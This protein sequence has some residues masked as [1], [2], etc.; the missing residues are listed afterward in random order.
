MSIDLAHSRA[1]FA[2]VFL[3]GFSS[4]L[5]FVPRA[6]AQQAG[7]ELPTV[8]VVATTPLGAGTSALNVPNETQ[9]LDSQQIETLSQSTITE[10]MARRTPGV[11]TTDSIGSPLAQSL[12]FR[13]ET[14]SPVPGTPQGL[15]VYMNGVRINESYGDVVNWDLIPTVA[16]DTAQ[17][18]TG[19]PVFGLNALAGAVVMNMKNGFTLQ[20]TEFD[21]QGGSDYTVQGS[22]QYGVNKGNWAYYVATEGVRT[23]GYRYFGQSDVERAYGDVGYRAEGNEVHLSMTGGADGL[24]VAGSTPLILSQQNPASVFTTPQTTNT[25]AEMI[26][27]SDESH[28]NDKLKFNGDIYFRNYGQAHVDGN[29]SNFQS[30]GGATLCNNGNPTAI[31]DTLP[32]GSLYGEIDRNWTHTES[33]GATAQLTYDDKIFGHHNTLTAGVSVDHGWTH[34]VGNSEIGSLATNFVV[35]GLGTYINEPASD[36]SPVNLNAQNT[37]LGIY[38]LDDFD[39]TDRLTLHAGARFNDA[40]INLNDL[41]GAS[42]NLNANNNFNRINPVVGATFKI[43]PDI[44]AYASYSEANRAPTP[45]ELGCSSPSQPCMIDN[46]LVSDPPLKQVVARTVEAGF[47]G[48]NPISGPIPGRLDWSANFYRTENQN[49]IYNVQSQVTGFGYFTNAGDTLRQGVD[50]GATFTTDRWDAYASYSYIQATFLTPVQLSSPNNPNATC[51][52]ATG[53]ECVMPG[54]NL[55]GIP[56][57]KF[58]I[59]FDYEILPKW[60]V[61]ADLVYRSG[62]YYVGDEIN[63]LPQV[64][65]FA[66]LNLRT[67]YQVNNNVQVFGLVNNALDYRYNTF[68]ALFETDSTAG[69]AGF[70]QFNDPR[71]VTVGPPLEI[72]VGIKATL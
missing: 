39:I 22:A 42:P 13:G 38:V 55:P 20:G 18:V 5:V 12:N 53:V 37:Y 31:P 56:R 52:G 36:V 2:S 64:P 25:T 35:T 29:I 19:N 23:N 48:D 45:L 62:Q 4:S 8:E 71:S 44:S 41:T 68:G 49:D 26:T 60:K 3:V 58:K 47:K 30:C 24:G 65:G 72:Y 11:S 17:I 28:I 67:S 50:L 10:D 43:T 1:L 66:T 46:F 21:L 14:A 70:P 7:G 15:A 63:S 6:L 54:D 69:F 61:G 9:T 32:A 51:N 34:F 59:G 40:Q 16:I 57:H 27:L 33:T